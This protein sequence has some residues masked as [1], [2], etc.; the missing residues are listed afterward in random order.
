MSRTTSELACT[1]L[2]RTRTENLS[3][4][5]HI[6]LSYDRCRSIVNA[7]K[8]TKDDILNLSE[9]YWA[10]QTD[11]IHAIDAGVLTLLNIHYNL[12]TGTLA[13]YASDRPDIAAL[14]EKLLRFEI[15]GQ[16]CLTEIGHGLDVI[17]METTAVMLSNGDFL[18][19]TPVPEAAKYMPPTSPCG[20]PVVAVVFARL[21][22]NGEDRG[23]RPFVVHLSDGYNMN[24]NIICKVLPPRGGSRPFKHTLTYFKQVRL[25]PTA[26]LGT[27]E[28]EKDARAA[29]FKNIF[30]VISGTL[31]MGA[32][33]LSG[34]RVSC[35]IAGRYNLRRKVTDSF[36]GRP[37]A[38]INFSTQ[39]IPVLTS[40]AQTLVMQAYTET[41]RLS[42]VEAKGD[43]S[44]QHLIASIFKATIYQFALSIPLV[45]G[46]RCGAQGL[47]AVNQLSVIH[48]D[49]RGGAIAEGDILVT[50]IR[51]AVEII[52]GRIQ[53]PPATDPTSVLYK[54][55]QAS[56][57]GLRWFLKSSTSHRDPEFEHHSLPQCQA[58]MVA[59]GVRLA[60]ES[61]M[62]ANIDQRVLDLFIA[63]VMKLDPA[64]YSESAGIS[65]G[66]QHRME[67]DCAM[68]LLP[69]LE[70]LLAK[71]DVQEYIMAPIV[72]DQS[73]NAFVNSLQTLGYAEQEE[74]WVSSHL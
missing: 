65:R 13:T 74:P 3:F 36:T 46:D 6:S 1:S 37:R 62:A 33:A 61:A 50:S 53:P 58:L 72:S 70:S 18:L 40:I 20:I 69:Q 2:W 67:V 68:A 43:I 52:L 10:F 44:R 26:L 7:F 32:S 4:E 24:R 39:Y 9:K 25:P 14:V 11:P 38:I 66:D 64:W 51:F 48:A 45:L 54:H 8:L 16:Y 17:N 47:S 27:P 55:E 29:F 41:A 35:Y 59:I 63:S 28:R 57:N 19:D 56:I 22:V 49:L 30:R 15:S 42:F 21:I 12:C 73:W 23:I 71:L 31:C 60:Y 5:Q 34:M